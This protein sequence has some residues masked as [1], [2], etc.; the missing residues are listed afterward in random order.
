MSTVS[1]KDS[2]ED[3]DLNDEFYVIKKDG[4]TRTSHKVDGKAMAALFRPIYRIL[5]TD[6]EALQSIP[7]N[8]EIKLS[9]DD[10]DSQNIAPV[11]LNDDKDV[12][13]LPAGKLYKIIVIVPYNGIG[14][15]DNFLKLT[16]NPVGGAVR[17]VDAWEDTPALY[18][19]TGHEGTL[20]T[21]IDLTDTETN[22]ELCLIIENST[23]AITQFISEPISIIIE[24]FN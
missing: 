21:L 8:S 24:E 14:S 23:D 9:I 16:S 5:L 10:A 15:S 11:T 12:I 22:E 13:T 20:V 2:I 4:E 3:L 7:A 18:Y 17:A 6:T 19:S 1:S